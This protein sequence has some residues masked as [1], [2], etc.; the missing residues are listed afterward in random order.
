MRERRPRRI[1]KGK[2]IRRIGAEESQSESAAMEIGGLYQRKETREKCSKGRRLPNLK[3]NGI[4]ETHLSRLEVGGR[5]GTAGGSASEGGGWIPATK[6]KGATRF[7]L[8]RKKKKHRW[9]NCRKRGRGG[10]GGVK[11]YVHLF[12]RSKH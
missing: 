3:E 6:K 5:L 4:R 7:F 10:R 1:V 8:N 12:G 2:K 9:Q 11:T